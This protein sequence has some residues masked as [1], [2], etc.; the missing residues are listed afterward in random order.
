MDVQLI[1]AGALR[2][3]PLWR[4]RKRSGPQSVVAGADRQLGAVGDPQFVEQAMQISAENLSVRGN[5][6]VRAPVREAPSTMDAPAVMPAP[7]A[8]VVSPPESIATAPLS[9]Q[10]DSCR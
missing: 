3:V 8:M 6:A 2:F 5:R 10:S 1:R 4:G 9:A 7:G